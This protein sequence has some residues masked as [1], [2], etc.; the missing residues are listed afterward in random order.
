MKNVQ[1]GFTLIELMIVIAIIG[2]LASV[3]VPQYKV[4]TQRATSTTQVLAAMRPMQFA[5]SEHAARYAETPSTTQ[6]DTMMDPIKADGTGTAS[7]MIKTVVYAQTSSSVATLTVTFDTATGIPAD[8]SGKTVIVTGTINSAGAIIFDVT[9]G[10]MA[11]N[12]RPTL[13]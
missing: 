3:A 1:K 9:G 7:A 10:S 12:L 2:I 5:I 8:L 11:V 6:Y 13:K 4:Y